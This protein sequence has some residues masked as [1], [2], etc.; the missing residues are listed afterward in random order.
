MRRLAW[1][2]LCPIAFAQ[3]QGIP[4]EPLS[5]TQYIRALSLDLRGVAPEVADDAFEPCE[6]YSGSRKGMVFK[7]GPKGLGCGSGVA[8][9]A[10][11]T[12][13]GAARSYYTDK[14]GMLL[15]AICKHEVSHDM[16]AAIARRV[17]RRRRRMSPGRRPMPLLRRQTRWPQAPHRP[18]PRARCCL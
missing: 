18:N 14:Y 17:S 2:A 3:A 9:A 13:I 16:P 5:T 4:S 11:P 7:M 15:L 12:P 10:H 1:L 8:R 6:A